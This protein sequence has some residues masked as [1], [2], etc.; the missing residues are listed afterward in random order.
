M[1][2]A[3]LYIII[4]IDLILL[5][6]FFL[7]MTFYVK[8]KVTQCVEIQ[9]KEYEGVSDQVTVAQPPKGMSHKMRETTAPPLE[10]AGTAK[11]VRKLKDKGF[12]KE[13]MAGQMGISTGEVDILLA[14]SDM[15]KVA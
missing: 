6:L 15:R 12:S 9:W 1:S 10:T 11:E 7:F 8:E 5:L 2:L 4:G 14:L 13:Q 3:T